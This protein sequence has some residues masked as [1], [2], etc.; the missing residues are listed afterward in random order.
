MYAVSECT[1]RFFGNFQNL[2]EINTRSSLPLMISQRFKDCLEGHLKL[3]VSPFNFHI[4][5]T[6]M[7]VEPGVVVQML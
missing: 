1:L 5:I 4:D 2:K 3:R 7:P 6:E